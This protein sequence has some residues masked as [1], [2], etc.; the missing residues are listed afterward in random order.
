MEVSL[1]RYRPNDADDL[2]K[3][4]KRA[5]HEAEVLG[6]KVREEQKGGA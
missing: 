2:L 4:N 6:D 3:S 1:E 5:T